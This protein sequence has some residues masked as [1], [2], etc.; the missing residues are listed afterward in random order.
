MYWTGRLHLNRQV[1]TL[2]SGLGI[3]DEVFL[4]LQ[5]KMLLD[6]ADMLLYNKVALL[7]LSEVSFFY[8]LNHQSLTILDNSL[9]NISWHE[10]NNQKKK[11]G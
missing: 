11:K 8:L 7:A 5:E 9:L 3:P 6:I 2:L 10:K 1:I 4:G